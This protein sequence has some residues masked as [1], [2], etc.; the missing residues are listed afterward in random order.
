MALI[1]DI[2][3]MLVID[4]DGDVL[5]HDTLQ[6]SNINVTTE[7]SDV[8]A[9]RGDA[10][11]AILHGKR[12]IEITGNTPTFKLETLAKH[13]GTDIITGEG[14]AW[15]FPK[16]Y[17]VAGDSTDG[18]TFELDKEPLDIDKVVIKK[19]DGT[20]VLNAAVTGKSVSIEDGL[21]DG[22]EVQ[23]LTY[24]YATNEKTQQLDINASKFPADV[25]I[26]LQTLEI[27]H[28]EQ[29]TNYIQFEYA[30]VKPS[31]D[32]SFNTSSAREASVQE[33]SFRVLK[34]ERS[35][36]IGTIKRIPIEG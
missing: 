30:R 13:V 21:T 10:L 23:V 16:W 2:F 36:T 8:N 14:V 7:T 24:T 5:A 3:E 33:M 26:V 15:A 20:E 32:F 9:G 11:I 18:Y 17:K 1:A 31:S 4:R 29:P 34:P 27:G 12:E 19:T 28:D 22:E 35:D 6:E 25:R